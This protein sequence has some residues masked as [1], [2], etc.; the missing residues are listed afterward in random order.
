VSADEIITEILRLAR[1]HM[2][3]RSHSDASYDASEWCDQKSVH[4]SS[5]ACLKLEC[6][7]CLLEML[8]PLTKV[9]DETDEEAT[10]GDS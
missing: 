10:K 3:G 5:D 9:R 6:R 4:D 2:P 8:E 1:P 7:G